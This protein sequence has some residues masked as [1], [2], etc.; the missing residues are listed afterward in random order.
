MASIRLED[1][2]KERLD[3]MCELED[4]SHSQA[5]E[6]ALNFLEGNIGIIS[7]DDQDIPI[8]MR[9]KKIENEISEIKGII[10]K[11]HA[12]FSAF[13]EIVEKEILKQPKV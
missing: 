9:F 5:V 2:V 8:E 3:K 12:T 6:K 7:D 4:L 11:D 10:Q 13:I 1:D